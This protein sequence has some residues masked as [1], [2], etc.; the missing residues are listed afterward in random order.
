MKIHLDLLMQYLCR[1]E[2][3]NNSCMTTS[4]SCIIPYPAP[5]PLSLPRPLT[6]LNDL[7]PN[8]RVYIV[9][10]IRPYVPVIFLGAFILGS[11][12]GG[13]NNITEPCSIAVNH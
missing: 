6:S 3:G 9:A 8:F 12:G 7:L 4:L 5:S 13:K 11:A 10:L 1:S 2:A